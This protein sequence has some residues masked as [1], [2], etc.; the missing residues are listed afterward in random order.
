[1]IKCQNNTIIS[2]NSTLIERKSFSKSASEIMELNKSTNMTDKIVESI[3]GTKDKS[4]CTN[5][6]ALR[7][8]RENNT[9]DC[10]ENGDVYEE[11]S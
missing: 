9:D 7:V 4:L 11:Y 6:S 2:L 1:M 10:E 3:S 8:E 5:D